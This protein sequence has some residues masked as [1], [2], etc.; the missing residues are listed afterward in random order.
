MTSEDKETIP[1]IEEPKGEATPVTDPI[2][3]VS[4]SENEWA[5]ISISNHIICLLFICYSLN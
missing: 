4:W 2:K 1:K 3:Q 5:L